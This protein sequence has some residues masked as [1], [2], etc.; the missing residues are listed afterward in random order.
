MKPVALTFFRSL[1]DPIGR[2]RDGSIGRVSTTWPALICR[3]SVPRVVKKKHEAPGFSLATYVSDRRS[4]ANVERVYAV[5]LDLDHF[6]VLPLRMKRTPGLIVP[7]PKWEDA[8]ARFEKT[9]C[10]L[11]TTWSSSKETPRVRVFIRLDRPV[12]AEEYRRVYAFCADIAERNGFLVDR[13]AS[14]PSRFWFLPSIPPRGTYRHAVCAG[15]VIKADIALETYPAAPAA[16]APRPERS[17]PTSEIDKT[18]ERAEKYL[19]TCDGAIQGQGGSN[20][21]FIVCMKI[22]RG[23]DLDD[24][25]AYRLLARWNERCSPPWSE[26]D[27]RRKIR[28]AAQRGT[29]PIGELRDRER[30]A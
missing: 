20:V 29:M 30:A 3:L 5:G 4:L 8:V 28:E 6:D 18:I 22:A 10:F 16:Q 11:H 21:T 24:D 23:F 7:A 1:T 2:L 19:E 15:K 17:A 14:D 26:R 25:T 9:E 12:T 27:L 13:A